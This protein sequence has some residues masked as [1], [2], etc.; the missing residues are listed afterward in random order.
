MPRSETQGAL[1]MA[2][3]PVRCDWSNTSDGRRKCYAPFGIVMPCLVDTKTIKP[4]INEAFVASSGD[5]ITDYNDL[6]CLFACRV[7]S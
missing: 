2:S 1:C 3:Y 4:I 7:A 6:Y 5:I